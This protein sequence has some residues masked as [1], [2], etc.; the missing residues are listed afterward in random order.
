MIQL[1]PYQTECADAID[2]ELVE[3]DSTLAVMATGT[4]KTEV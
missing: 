4:G 2:R 3:H 1:R